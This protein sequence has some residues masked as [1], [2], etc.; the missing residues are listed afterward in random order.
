MDEAEKK[1]EKIIEMTA[2][3]WNAWMDLPDIIKHQ[4]DNKE[5]AVDIHHIQNRIMAINYKQRVKQIA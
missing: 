4:S 1:I 2:D 5:M 3:L